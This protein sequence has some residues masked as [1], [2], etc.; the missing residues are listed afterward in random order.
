MRGFAFVGTGKTTVAKIY[1]E[2]LRD[3]GLLS[4]GDVVMK[5]ASDFIGSVIGESGKNT[6]AILKQAEGSVL[7]IDEAY[8][9]YGKDGKDPYKTQVIDTIVEQVQAVPGE[10]K[11]VVMLGY[12][13]E[14]EQMMRGSNPGL[15]RRFQ[16]ENA[17]QFEDY[18]ND[19]LLE[20]LK[21]KMKKAGVTADI[22]ALMAAVDKL[23][24]QRD[25]KPPF[26][27]GGAVAN[28][29]S[30]A[31]QRK[32]GRGAGTHPELIASDFAPPDEEAANDTNEAVLFKGLIGCDEIIEKLKEYKQ[33]FV[34]A[35]EKGQDPLKKLSLNFRFVGAPGTHVI[36]HCR[37]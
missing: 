20:I 30:E 11:C 12:R 33:T 27:N 24:V 5:A 2:I 21:L 13:E 32:A 7:V 19:E 16:L 1:A 6:T 35:K 8:G 10:D 23:A 25:T 9:L 34:R 22:E 3:F 17:F 29:L 4:K 15:Q 28:L 14:M 18:S 37:S 31:L 26:G 36:L